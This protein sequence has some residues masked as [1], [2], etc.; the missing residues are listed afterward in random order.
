MKAL[1]VYRGYG[2]KL[3][4][5]IIDLQRISIIRQGIEVEMF[6]ITQGGMRGYLHALKYLKKCVLLHK[7]DIVHAHYSF[8]GVLVR[9]A[10]KKPVICSLM[11][12]DLLQVGWFSRLFIRLFSQWMWNTTIVKSVEMQKKIPWSQLVPNGVDLENFREISKPEA[13]KKTGFD[14]ACKH[15]LFVTQDP[16]SKVKNI[17]LAES[18]IR[19]LNNPK[20]NF[21]VI[22]NKSFEELPY[23]YSAADALLL[24]SH[25]EGSPNVIK[26]AM[27]CNCPIVS[28]NAGDVKEVIHNTEG[29]YLTSFDPIDIAN[30]IEMALAFGKRTNGRV[31]VQ[32]LDSRIVASRIVSI[33]EKVL[34][35][36]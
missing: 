4:N 34:T 7:F 22:S 14:L 18:A 3:S 32:H 16:T 25:S 6:P 26:E 10:T 11:G 36:K 15:I 20:L 29:C 5:S 23:Y 13:F 31:H 12:S 28:T 8:S 30:K 33:Y 9:L 27:A 24:T 21:H 1:F 17:S 19:L 2:P 35:P